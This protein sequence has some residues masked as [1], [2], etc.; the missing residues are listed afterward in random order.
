MEDKHEALKAIGNEQPVELRTLASKYI[1]MADKVET[2]QYI[3]NQISECKQIGLKKYV[4]RSSGM[5][6]LLGADI[7]LNKLRGWIELTREAATEFI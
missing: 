5:S 2:Q 3:N 1:Q 6:K 4:L 7:D